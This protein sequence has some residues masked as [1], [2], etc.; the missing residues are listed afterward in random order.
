M[1]PDVRALPGS[2]ATRRNRKMRQYKY[3]PIISLTSCVI[4]G[5]PL[6][7]LLKNELIIGV[8]I[9]ELEYATS[10]EQRQSIQ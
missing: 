8:R 7:L 3:M 1:E 2:F 4:L 10:V 6:N 5:S 9:S